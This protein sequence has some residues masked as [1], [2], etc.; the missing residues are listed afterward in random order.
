MPFQPALAK[1]PSLVWCVAT[2]MIVGCDGV[3]SGPL[4]CS[5]VFELVLVFFL[6]FF[7]VVEV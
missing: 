3:M 1:R 4:C 2:L 6:V 7:G 5:S